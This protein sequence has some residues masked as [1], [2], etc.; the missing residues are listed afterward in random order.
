[1]F[2]LVFAWLGDSVFGGF[3][4]MGLGWL[5][6]L[7]VLAWLRGWYNIGILLVFGWDVCL[8]IGV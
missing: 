1:M 3:G 8:G 6:E 7:W 2:W 4:L 5:C